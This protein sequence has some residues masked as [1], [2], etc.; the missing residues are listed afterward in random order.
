MRPC[1]E[2]A[3][4]LGPFLALELAPEA[5]AEVRAHLACCPACRA[6]GDEAEPATG[7]ALRLADTPAEDG[8]EFVAAVLAGV[9]QHRVERQLR[10]RWRRWASVAAAL[11]VVV[12][13][14]SLP[15]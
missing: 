1:A 8:E 11:F 10:R 14:G 15:R 4:L 12:L 7:I 6:A 9:H 3:A 13:A 2:V 5:E